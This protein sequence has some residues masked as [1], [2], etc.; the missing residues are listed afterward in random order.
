MGRRLPT[1]P[2]IALLAA[3]AACSSD[4]ATAPGSDVTS[5][6][7]SDGFVIDSQTV[8]T[9]DSTILVTEADT[10][11]GSDGE[12]SVP[13]AADGVVGPLVACA[14]P[15]SR[16]TSSKQIGPQ[17]GTVKLAPFTLI[18]PAGALETTEVVTLTRTSPAF[19]AVQATVGDSAH[20]QFARPVAFVVRI[21]KYCPEVT[22]E[23]VGLLKGAWLDAPGGPQSL[24]SW[25]FRSSGKVKFWTEHFSSYGIAW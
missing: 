11:T 24:V 14:A 12:A 9:T 13:D 19:L 25:R 6:P 15:N 2:A 21:T 3:I 17:G 23:M 18:I 22:A 4:R 5:P 10:S 7:Y 16:T 8:V 20:Y 1:L